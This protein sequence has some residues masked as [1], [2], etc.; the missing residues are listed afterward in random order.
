ML[1]NGRLK[2]VTEMGKQPSDGVMLENGRSICN[3]F[4]GKRKTSVVHKLA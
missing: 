3:H 2:F 1:E 4:G